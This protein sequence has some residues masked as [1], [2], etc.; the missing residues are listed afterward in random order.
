[1]PELQTLAPLHDIISRQ[2][3]LAADA[4]RLTGFLSKVRQMPALS[5]SFF[6]VRCTV[7]C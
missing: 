6:N 2:A 7:A 5:A 4:A 3:V 1:V